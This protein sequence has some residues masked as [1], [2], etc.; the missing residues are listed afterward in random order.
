MPVPLPAC[1]AVK[2]LIDP[3]QGLIGLGRPNV[4]GLIAP[5]GARSELRGPWG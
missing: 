3:F 5:G 1:A 2:G 4:P